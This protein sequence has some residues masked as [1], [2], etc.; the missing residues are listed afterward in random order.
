MASIGTA[1]DSLVAREQLRTFHLTGRGLDA[2]VPQGP[3]RPSLLE[4]LD[5]PRFEQNYPLYVAPAETPQPLFKKLQTVVERNRETFPILR[6]YLELIAAA[7]GDLVGA[8]GCPI[9]SILD[10]ALAAAQTRVEQL[11][12]HPQSVEKEF[13]ALRKALTGE[14][15]LI[16]LGDSTLARLHGATLQIGRQEARA[17]F[18]QD[19]RVCVQRLREL[20]AADDRTSAAS[21][22]GHLAASLGD[23]A[24]SFLNPAV[25]AAALRRRA[26]PVLPMEPE[27]R[28]RCE[29]ALATLQ[30]ATC[31]LD[32]QPAVLTTDACDRAIDLC[33]QQ[34]QRYTAVW[35]ALRIG[36]LEVEC[37]FDPAIH[38]EALD[39]FDWSMAHPNELAAVPVVVAVSTAQQIENSLASFGRLLQSGL[40]IQVLITCGHGP[41]GMLACL[42][43][44]YQEAFALQSSIACTDHLLAG[45][46]EMARTLRPACAV[47]AVSESWT[48]AALLP[49]A[50]A[51]PLYRYHPE[52]GESWFQRFAMHTDRPAGYEQLTFAHIA[53]LMLPWRNHFRVL[54]EVD[55]LFPSLLVT[56]DDGEQRPAVFTRELTKLC[57]DAEKRWRFLAELATPKVLKESSPAPIP[58]A[59]DRA[60]LDGATEAIQRVIAILREG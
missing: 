56:D 14:G 29:A 57:S 25:L 1:T 48:E 20:L 22:T 53:A 41:A 12:V 50:R 39:A 16:S 58:G 9:V 27:R 19:L 3:L 33:R 42:P 17:S 13:A 32:R 18:A 37:A 45:L 2:F 38:L 52:L 55:P 60:R 4:Q 46:S 15:S 34:L 43:I 26:N 10:A 31:E 21:S 47:V 35:K 11:H 59:E 54:P 44:V 5:L 8:A 51:C 40:P 28:A 49:L 36:R 23:R 24:A 7:F 6:D 30:D